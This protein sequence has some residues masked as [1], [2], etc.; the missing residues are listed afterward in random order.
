MSDHSFLEL[1]DLLEP[2]DLVVV[3]ET[4]VR[5]ARLVGT[6]AGTGGR[7]ELL[8]LEHRSDGTWE[9]LARPAR[10]L[11]PGVVIELD[12]MTATIVT[13][14]EEGKVTVQLDADDPERA[15]AAVGTV[16]LPPY[17][18]GDLADPSRYQT[19][20]ASTPGSAAAPT[21][22]LHFTPEVTRCLN[23]NGMPI[24]TVDLHVSLDTFRP[25][26]VENIEDHQMHSEW[27]AVSEET[28]QA[29]SATRRGGGNVVAIGTTVVRT[30]ESMAD[31]AGGVE[32]G[33]TRTDLFLTPGSDVSVVDVLVTNFHLPGSTLL[34]LLAAF[35]GDRWRQAYDTA[36]NR[37]YRFLSFGDAMLAVR[38]RT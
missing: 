18:T 36:L 2:G 30:L 29:I 6:R 9:A 21:A 3:N 7:V 1:A 32:A 24:A 8:L 15:I 17:F 25:I 34:V 22:G 23:A 37:G 20:F 19:M 11:R 26:A 10:R 33:E 4:K 16:P 38:A 31:G 27:C 28:A 35:M 13:Q 12:E 5:A 14:P